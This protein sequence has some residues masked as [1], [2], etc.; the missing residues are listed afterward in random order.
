MW[1]LAPAQYD[2]RIMRGSER[3]PAFRGQLETPP[4]YRRIRNGILSRL[5]VC[6]I[7][8]CTLANPNPPNYCVISMSDYV[9]CTRCGCQNALAQGQGANQSKCAKCGAPL[10][11]AADT[12][13]ANP[14]QPPPAIAQTASSPP[15]G[16][17][18]DKQFR[19]GSAVAVP[20][21]MLGMLAAVFG[22]QGPSVGVAV[23]IGLGWFIV[24]FGIAALFDPNIVRAAG[25]FGTH[26]PRRYKLIA[27]AIGLAALVCSLASS[28]F[29]LMQ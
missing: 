6:C 19:I 23:V 13:P 14:Y 4:G 29:V 28:Y 17:P 21:I 22:G 26:L 24:F 5:V 16:G 8:I 18:T 1:K 7:L 9:T 12:S 10:A 27:A 20:L 25:K 3:Q 11:G 2:K 15:H